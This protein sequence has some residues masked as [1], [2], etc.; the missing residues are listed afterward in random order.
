MS[1]FVSEQHLALLGLLKNCC[2]CGVFF[3]S[4]RGREGRLQME[5]LKPP[6]PAACFC[7]S[8]FRPLRQK[9]QGRN[10]GSGKPPG[11]RVSV[12]KGCAA[13]VGDVAAHVDG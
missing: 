8:R 1:H 12:L 4:P 7:C 9:I 10:K 3:A 13:A 5:M 2:S 6:V 11:R